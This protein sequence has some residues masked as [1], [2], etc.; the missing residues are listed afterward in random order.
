MKI[1]YY[2]QTFC[3]L[4]NIINDPNNNVTH[5]HLS[6]IHFDTD[7]MHLN[8]DSPYSSNFSSLWDELGVATSKKNIK[9][10][11]MVGGAGGAF[12]QLFLDFDKY[13]KM[14]YDLIN[15]KRDIIKG[16]DLDIE[17][18]VDL[19]NVVKLIRRLKRDFGKDFIMSMAPIESSLETDN[20]G[21]GGF[22]YKDLY[23][24]VGDLIDYFNVQCYYDYSKDTFENIINNGY[25]PEKI[26]MGMMS[27]QYNNKIPIIIKELRSKYVEFGGIFD[28]EYNDAVKKWNHLMDK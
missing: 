8:D 28:W 15:D 11:L 13:Y 16:V 19:N 3:G 27:Y 6:S 7:C 18:T 20:E 2:Y 10:I 9:V 12:Q 25:P 22:I 1:I 14:L 17:E 26:N 24:I 23:K 5:I 21:M 4:K